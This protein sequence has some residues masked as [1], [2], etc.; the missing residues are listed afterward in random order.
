MQTNTIAEP[1]E[2][3]RRIVE[4]AIQKTVVITKVFSSVRM[5]KF[6]KCDKTSASLAD[7]AAQAL[8]VTAIHN[9]PG[10]MIVGEEGKALIRRDPKIADP[11]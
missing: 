1:Y 8:L 9:F 7:F 2:H 4:L 6:R 11:V 10:D 3:E 5:G